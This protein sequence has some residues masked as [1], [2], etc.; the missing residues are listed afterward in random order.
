MI[1]AMPVAAAAFTFFFHVTDFATRGDF[2]V[3]PDDAAA[4][5]SCKAKKPNETHTALF[6]NLGPNPRI[7]GRQFARRSYSYRAKFVPSLN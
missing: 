7:E 3:P 1:A 2:A 4:G 5:K 6:A